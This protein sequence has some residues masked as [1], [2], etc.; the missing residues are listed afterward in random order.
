MT[1]TEK[2]ILDAIR[3]WVWS[4]FYGA[5]EVHSMISDILEDGADEAF[6][7]S[8]VMP[9]FE[10]KAAAELSWPQE[11]DCDRLDRAFEE[12]NTKGIVALQN[13]G[14]TMSDG[15]SDVSEVLHERGRGGI[16]GYCFYHGQDLER[17][18]A[19]VGLWIAFG[20]LNAES[21]KKTEI[22]QIIRQVLEGHGFAVEWNG[23][24]ETRLS[25]PK[26]DWKRRSRPLNVKGR[27]VEPPNNLLS[28]LFLRICRAAKQ[29]HGKRD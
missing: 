11:T 4:G 12:L 7:R 25:I 10:K 26:F 17:A 1:D 6:L 9:E 2:Y 19:G 16:N 18:V 21:A 13:A 24:P 14:Y 22:G 5:E 20:D 29:I 15:T 23:D 3:T 8:S 27:A 28:K